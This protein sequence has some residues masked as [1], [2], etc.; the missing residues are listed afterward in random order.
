MRDVLVCLDAA[1]GKERWKVDF[2]EKFG[3]ALPAFGFVCSPLVD[4][5]AVYVQAA[6]A[7]VKLDKK[8]GEVLWRTLQDAGGMNGS[9]FSSPV[10]TKWQAKIRL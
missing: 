9:A 8:T 2:V 6:A 1:S 7:F 5:K 4:D 3:T 10:R